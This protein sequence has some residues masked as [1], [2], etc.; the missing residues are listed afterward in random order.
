[1]SN[2]DTFEK[3]ITLLLSRHPDGGFVYRGSVFPGVVRLWLK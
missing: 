2:I 1:M 3:L